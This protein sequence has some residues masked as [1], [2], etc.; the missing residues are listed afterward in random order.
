M[1]PNC[2]STTYELILYQDIYFIHTLYIIY[3]HIQLYIMYIIY[4]YI[5]IYIYIRVALIHQVALFVCLT[6]PKVSIWWE[7]IAYKVFINIFQYLGV[8]HSCQSLLDGVSKTGRFNTKQVY[9]FVSLAVVYCL[10]SLLSYILVP[11]LLTCVIKEV[12]QDQWCLCFAD[13][14][15][16]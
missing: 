5:Y 13:N 15:V 3:I 14:T 9:H 12:D 11:S 8:A 2:F 4:I 1:Q 6:L 16:I 7:N 10:V